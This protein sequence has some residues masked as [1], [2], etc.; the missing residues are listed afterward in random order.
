[1]QT[2]ADFCSLSEQERLAYCCSVLKREEEFL[3]EH[4]ANIPLKA[5][6]PEFCHMLIPDPHIGPG[7]GI[8][9]RS[10]RHLEWRSLP[11]ITLLL[12]RGK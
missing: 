11:Q 8:S 7:D 9:L 10:L 1:M 5:H 3:L 4:A 2:H 12:L 6:W